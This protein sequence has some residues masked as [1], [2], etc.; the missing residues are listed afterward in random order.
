MALGYTVPCALVDTTPRCHAAVSLHCT[1]RSTSL[2]TT[3]QC[4]TPHYS[5][6]IYA[7]YLAIKAE[8]DGQL[9]KVYDKDANVAVCS[10]E[11]WSLLCGGEARHHHQLREATT[12]VAVLDWKK[13]S[14]RRLL[15]PSPL[16]RWVPGSPG[17][18]PLR[19]TDTSASMHSTASVRTP[20]ALSLTVRSA[21]QLSKVSP[22][23]SCRD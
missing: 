22:M 9:E 8:I 5:V 6:T 20:S 14:R 18:P 2:H 17:A 15:S 10:F 4:A 23:P 12:A 19:H 21:R 13:R 1:A 7:V 16:S 11:F 3:L